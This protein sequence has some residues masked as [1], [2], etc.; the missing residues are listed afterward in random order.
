MLIPSRFLSDFLFSARRDKEVVV[1]T[2]M[3]RSNKA[4][5]E[6]RQNPSGCGHS[7]PDTVSLLLNV[8]QTTFSSSLLVP[9][10]NGHASRLEGVL[11]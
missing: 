10:R 11:K 4:M 5:K 1:D 8:E 2:T 3:T 9:T 7:A 6:N